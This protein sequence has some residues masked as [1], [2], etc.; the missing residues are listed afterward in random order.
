MFLIKYYSFSYN[1]SFTE[2]Q[3]KFLSTVDICMTIRNCLKDWNQFFEKSVTSL[4]H[5]K[6]SD[7]YQSLICTDIY[8]HVLYPT[9]HQDYELKEI[10]KITKA[11]GHK[12]LIISLYM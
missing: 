12:K 3:I 4:K 6:N 1:T 11:K 10:C 8:R 7:E 9:I 2:F 5:I